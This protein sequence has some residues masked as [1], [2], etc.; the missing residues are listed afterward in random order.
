MCVNIISDIISCSRKTDVPAFLMPWVIERIG[1]GYVDVTNPYNPNQVS[2]I[3][4]DPLDVKCWVWCS[5]DFR[6]WIKEYQNNRCLFEQYK[7]HRFQFTINSP[8]E[9]ESGLHTPL[10]ERLKQLKYL[11]K[12]FGFDAMN[13]RFDPIVL[14]RKKD[15][16][17]ILNN[18]GKIDYIGNIG[19][20]EMIFSFAQLYSKATKR[21]LLRNKTLIDPPLEEKKEIIEGIMSKCD[22]YAIVLKNCSQEILQAING[23]EKSSCIDANKIE[24]ITGGSLSKAKDQ[25]Q[26]KA[27]ECHKSRDIGQYGGKFSCIHNCDYCYSHPIN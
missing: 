27:C 22:K 12:Q 10:D 9:L 15:S 26:R 8:S 13:Y 3:S 7:G 20:K 18:L 24:K 23:V 1:K 21:M 5:K 19:V 14:Y 6:C 11:L 16:S 4:L 25:S 2:R 17:K